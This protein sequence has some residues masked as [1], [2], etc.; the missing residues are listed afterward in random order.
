[1][2]KREQEY[3]PLLF[4]TTMRNPERIKDFLSI[5]KNYNGKVLTNSLVIEVVKELI[6]NGFY[7]T[8]FMKRSRVIQEKMKNGETLTDKELEQI[9]KNSPQN[10]QERGFDK[11]WASRFDTWYKLTKELGFVYYEMNKKIEF[12]KIGLMLVDNEHPEFEQQAFLNS[13]VKYQRNNPF[14]RVLNENAPLILL[15]ETIKRINQNEEF[16]GKGITRNEIPI[17]LCWRDNNSEA[18]YKQIIAIRGKYGYNPSGEVILEICDKQ[19]GGRHSSNK[20]KT[21]LQEYPDEFLRKMRLTG[22]ITI[23]GF[24]RFIDLNTKEM[25]KI[26][27]A[28]KTYSKYKKYKTERDYFDYMSSIDKGLFSFEVKPIIDIQIE[29]RLLIKWAEHY[30]WDKIKDELTKLSLNQSSKDEILRLIPAPMRLEFLTSL[31]I[32]IKYPEVIVKPNYISDDEGLPSSHAIGG[33]PDIECEEL[34]KYILVEVTMLTGTQQNIREMPSISR[35]LKD[36]IDLKQDAISLFIAP[37]IFDDSLRFSK[38][39]KHDEG[40]KIYP[41]SIKEFLSHIEKNNLLYV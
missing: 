10:H 32:V 12:S 26:N 33:K 15:L 40:L 24:G 14:K 30:K 18:L 5:L 4:T 25:Q 23:R 21:I 3:K 9:I 17:V 19:T 38:F 28:L 22:L 27:Y 2:A 11:G 29:R 7:E 31:A 1:M 39:I 35:H 13:F 41:F 34:R 20:D 16:N 6:K 8:M 37:I 36:R